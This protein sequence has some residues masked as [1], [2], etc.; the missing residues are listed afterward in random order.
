MLY[1]ERLRNGETGKTDVSWLSWRRN[2]LGTK[3]HKESNE[4]LALIEGGDSGNQVTTLHWMINLK[5]IAQDEK[6]NKN[7]LKA[8]EA[9]VKTADNLQRSAQ[10]LSWFTRWL[11][12]NE[13][14]IRNIPFRR[15]VEYNE[16][17]SEFQRDFTVNLVSQWV[18]EEV[19]KVQEHHTNCMNFCSEMTRKLEK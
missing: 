5:K 17:L 9:L 16:T 1:H 7:R 19:N 8:A 12:N 18:Q 3:L 6:S 2:T 15:V 11:P 10:Y 13:F 14:I 4:L